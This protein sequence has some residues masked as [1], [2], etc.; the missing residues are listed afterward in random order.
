MCKLFYLCRTIEFCV[1][2]HEI[3]VLC[4]YPPISIKAVSHLQM[5]VVEFGVV[6]WQV[7]TWPPFFFPYKRNVT[8]VTKDS[9]IFTPSV[10]TQIPI[11][12]HSKTIRGLLLRT[13]KIL[14]GHVCKFCI[15]QEPFLS[16]WFNKTI[17]TFRCLCYQSLPGS[18]TFRF[19]NPKLKSTLERTD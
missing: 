2:Q 13:Y 7:E 16:F 6:M 5:S 4:K 17:N 11:V 8:C 19:V 18:R 10:S 9:V 15:Y 1:I 12:N 14:E 3:Q